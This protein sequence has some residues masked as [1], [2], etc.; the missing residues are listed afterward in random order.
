MPRST[1]KVLPSC[2]AAHLYCS[3]GCKSSSRSAPPVP[4]HCSLSLL[5]PAS[6]PGCVV[7]CMVKCSRLAIDPMPSLMVVVAWLWV[8]ADFATGVVPYMFR[9]CLWYCCLCYFHTFVFPPFNSSGCLGILYCLRVDHCFLHRW[10]VSNHSVTSIA[11]TAIL[12]LVASVGVLVLYSAG[13][14]HF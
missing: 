3:P 7:H 9:Q 13:V 1:I 6:G 10:V 5:L 8:V 12:I 2:T 4:G 14:I 11:S